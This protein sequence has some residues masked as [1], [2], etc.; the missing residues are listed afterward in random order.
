MKLN[1]TFILRSQLSYKYNVCLYNS[2]DLKDEIKVGE[3]GMKETAISHSLYTTFINVNRTRII[4]GYRIVNGKN[5]DKG[6]KK[7]KQTWNSRIQ[8]W[9]LSQCTRQID[10]PQPSIILLF[11]VH[12]WFFC[13]LSVLF[14]CVQSYTLLSFIFLSTS[15]YNIILCKYIITS[16]CIYSLMQLNII[17]QKM[18]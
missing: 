13:P 17:S 10:S 3:T 7:T 14:C 11:H 5:A 16:S 8:A 6:Q 18:S 15:L 4:K 1:V 9:T 2:G 12:F